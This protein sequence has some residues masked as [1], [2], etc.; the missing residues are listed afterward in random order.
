VRVSEQSPRRGLARAS[1]R[2]ALATAAIVSLGS[3]AVAGGYVVNP[4][5]T[6]DQ[7]VLATLG[8]GA[9]PTVDP[10]LVNPWDFANAGTGPWVIA[11]TG[12]NGGGGVAGTA[13]VY[14]GTGQIMAPTVSI[15][16]AVGPAQGG[17]S[18]PVGPTGDVYAGGAG[19]LLPNGAPAQY[20]FDNLDGSISGWDGSS[21]SAQ[22]LVPGRTGGHLAAYTGLEIG[23]SGGQT[24]LYAANNIT[25]AIDV[26]NTALSPVTLAGAF[27]D[28]GPNPGGLLPFDIQ[29]VGGHMW[30]TYAEGGPASASAPLGSGFVSE[31]NMDGTFVRRFATGGT[32]SSPWGVAIA[33]SDF[34][35]YSNDV[36]IGNFNDTGGLGFISAYSQSGVF[37]GLLDENGVPIV[38]PGL[39]A[40]QFGAGGDNGPTNDL[41]FTAG[42]GVE[43]HGLFGNIAAVPEPSAWSI[44]LAGISLVG[45][46]FRGQRRRRAGT[47]LQA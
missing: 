17:M 16:Q 24:L 2:L 22:T 36:L 39:W 8:Y 27:V 34:G 1:R 45:A 43:N 21:A 5:V 4:L 20:I 10:A 14:S 33:P 44:M 31:F 11:N 32:L 46:G 7:S 38:L 29:N 19:F 3:A 9:A 12:G 47:V 37:Q 28:P 18:G 15:P 25:G 40:L 41:Y 30:V 13:T 35:A 23:A 42:I 6:D 26:F